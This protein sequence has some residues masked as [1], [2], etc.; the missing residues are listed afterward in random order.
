MTMN[1]TSRTVPAGEFKAKCLALLDRV[2]RTRESLVVTKRG[3][4]VA[5]IVPI[6]DLGQRPLAGSVR[7]HADIV[8]PLDETWDADR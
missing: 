6:E 1:R 5:R 4:A 7:Y 8:V 3:R 2:A